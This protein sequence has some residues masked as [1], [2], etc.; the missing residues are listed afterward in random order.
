[1]AAL[2]TVAAA[3]KTQDGTPGARPSTGDQW[4]AVDRADRCALARSA[5]AVWTSRYCVQSV[6]PLAT[7]GHLAPYPNSTAAAGRCERQVELGAAFCRWHQCAGPSARGWGKKGDPETEAL[8]R[9]RGGFSTKL[10]L[11]AEGGG[12]PLMFLVTA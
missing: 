7:G 5:R 11:R 3:A 12:K 10:H 4:H 9:S 2:G 6:L 1:M 8:G